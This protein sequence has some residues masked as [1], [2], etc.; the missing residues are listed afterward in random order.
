MKIPEILLIQ[1]EQKPGNLARILAV[2]GEEGVL[3][4]HLAAVRREA[5]HTVW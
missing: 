4:E 1:S 5:N 2:I 3:V